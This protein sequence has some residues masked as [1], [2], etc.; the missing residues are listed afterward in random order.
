LAL[1]T[2]ANVL[3]ARAQ[4][5][6]QPLASE[7]HQHGAAAPDREH[8]GHDMQV[9]REGSGTSWLPDTTPMYA[10]H[11]QRGDW[12]FMAHENAFLQFLHE[13]GDRGND[14]FGSINWVMGMAQRNVGPGRLQLRGMFSAEPWTI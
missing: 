11:W 5:A 3:P 4:A 8:E 9:A 2:G 10:I 12:Q 1:I 6:P 13:S 7:Q 14:Q